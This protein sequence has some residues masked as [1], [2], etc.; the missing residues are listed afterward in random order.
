MA[1]ATTNVGFAA[2]PEEAGGLSGDGPKDDRLKKSRAWR[3]LVHQARKI[4]V[5]GFSEAKHFI[6]IFN[7]FIKVLLGGGFAVLA[8]SQTPGA[9][10]GPSDQENTVT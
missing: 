5:P 6:A 8:C 9:Q 2:A 7:H 3:I 4:V 10:A 1:G